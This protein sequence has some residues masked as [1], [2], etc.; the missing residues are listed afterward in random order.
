MDINF[1]DIKYKT[2]DDEISAHVAYPSDGKRYPTIILIHEVF[3]VDAHIK[4]VADKIAEEGYVVIAPDL[5][6]SNKLSP[7][8][9]HENVAATLKFMM[10][11]PPEKHRDEDF[12]MQE[13][14]KLDEQ[15]RNAVMKV[16]DV[17]FVNR[18]IDLFVQYM[19]SGAD[20]ISGHAQSNGKM[21][22][23][24]FCF[25]GEM[26]INLACTG[27]TDASVIFY[28]GNPN[29]IDKIKG[30]KGAVMGLYGGEDA[31]VNSKIGELVN[32][33]VEYKRPFTIKVFPGAHHA[34]FNDTRPMYDKAAAEESWRMVTKFF[35][36]NLQ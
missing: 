13:M 25:G 1:E 34:F 21:G 31:R 24:G 33:L 32:A 9:T 7:I 29:P 30:V 23:V 15:T 28:G 3:G 4:S 36:D 18:P 10:S 19:A 14:E 8:L 27:R 12:R 16:N 6:S 35:K 17:L 20:Y 5:F 26:S 22:S 11:L 2:T